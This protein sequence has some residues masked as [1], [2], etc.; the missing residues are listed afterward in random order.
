M[1]NIKPY[2]I[3]IEPHYDVLNTPSIINSDNLDTFVE[4]AKNQF[5]EKFI[6]KNNFSWTIGEAHNDFDKKINKGK[7]K[8][9][10]TRNN[11][12]N[13]HDILLFEYYYT[14]IITIPDN[15]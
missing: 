15:I 14:D 11:P 9:Q 12:T 7:I 2:I 13:K 5:L 10:T 6:I 8:L 1:V 4:Y 3:I